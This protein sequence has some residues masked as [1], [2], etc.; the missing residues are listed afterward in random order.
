MADLVELCCVQ[1]H[2]PV[3]DAFRYHQFMYR[4]ADGE[5]EQG[6]AQIYYAE[7]YSPEKLPKHRRLDQLQLT[8][9]VAVP[10]AAFY[11]TLRGTW[12]LAPEG[13]EQDDTIFIKRP[14]L[15]GYDIDDTPE[16]TPAAEVGTSLCLYFYYP[17]YASH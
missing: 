6:E 11:P 3:S 5:G 12:T 13:V 16:I 14:R 7:C 2:D 10:P 4:R 15:C 9:I 8:N 17:W 1:H